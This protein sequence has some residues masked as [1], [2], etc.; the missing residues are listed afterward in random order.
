MIPAPWP[1]ALAAGLALDILLVAAIAIA[2]SSPAAARS[3]QAVSWVI[4]ALATAAIAVHSWQIT[5]AL[6]LLAPLPLV[7][8]ALW[9]LALSA[10]GAQDEAARTAAEEQQRTE[11]QQRAEAERKAARMST[12]LTEE[13]QAELAELDRRRAYVES[14]SSR[15]LALA[16]AEA[17]AAQQERLA[18]IRRDA[19]QQMATDEATAQIHV[20]RAELAQKIRLA[21]PVHTATQ[22]GTGPQ[23]PDD[24][25]G[26]TDTNLHGPTSVA[27]FGAM[28]ANQGG[29]PPAPPA[30]QQV[31]PPTPGSAPPGASPAPAAPRGPPRHLAYVA[32]AITDTT[33][34]GPTS[35]A[36]FGAMFANQ[37][38]AP[39][40]P[41]V[42][43]QVPPHTPG[44]APRGASPAEGAL[45][46]PQ[47][48]LD[49]VTQAGAE[50]TVKGAA[51]QMGVHPRT[52]RRYR[53]RLAEAG[54]DVSAL[55][56]DLP[57]Q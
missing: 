43:Q 57:R 33:L 29:A 49:Y 12:D 42:D 50:A 31:P 22:I 36:G 4:A 45:S 46:G 53:E 9:G 51:R 8:K 21:A 32:P 44:S 6:V 11:E 1:G 55:G 23:V 10:K 2:W 35:V 17:Q 47:R 38:G 56:T 14:R 27:G 16:E 18:Q 19:E 3:A 39:P 24:A 37:G 34:H 52:I 25:S 41:P 13:Q 7:A 20:R 30:D 54:H 15:E 26:I 5:P 48:L 28:F 40:A